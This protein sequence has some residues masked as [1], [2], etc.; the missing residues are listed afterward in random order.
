VVDL[1][2]FDN[3]STRMAAVLVLATTVAMIGDRESLGQTP[4]VRTSD[5]FPL[6]PSPPTT[7]VP[8][9]PATHSGGLTKDTVIWPTRSFAIPFNVTSANHQVVEVQLFV[10]QGPG[11]P[12]RLLDRQPST[13]TEFPFEATSDGLHWFATR[14]AD[15][16]REPQPA[17]PILPQLK[18]LIDST[19]PEVRLIADAD[20]SGRVDVSVDIHDET[21]LRSLQLHYATD[22]VRNWQTVDIQALQ[23]R[24][25]LTFHPAETWQQL[26][27]Q[28]V[29][30]DSAGHQRIVSKLLHRPRI[31]AQDLLPR[32]SQTPSVENLRPSDPKLETENRAVSQ[33]AQYRTD[34]SHPHVHAQQVGVNLG[35]EMDT[36]SKG[37]VDRIAANPY[38]SSFPFGGALPSPATPD[39]VTQGFSGPITK[40]ATPP[41]APERSSAATRSAPATWPSGPATLDSP[42]NRSRSVADAMRPLSSEPSPVHGSGSNHAPYVHYPPQSPSASAPH[43]RGFHAS[44]SSTPQNS[45][46]LDGASGSLATSRSIETIPTPTDAEPDPL[47]VVDRDTSAPYETRRL[48]SPQL[49]AQLW[50]GRV[51]SRYSD[52]R[53][54]S[55]EY[56]LEAVGANGAEAIELWGTTDGAKSWQHWGNDPDLVSPFDIETKEEGVFGFR[57]VVLGRNGLATPRPLAGETPDIAVTVDTTRPVVR[58][59]GAQYGVGDRIGSLVIQYECSDKYLAQRPITLAFSDSPE[60]PWTTIAAGLQ[61]HGE[62][63]WPADPHL[64][65]RLYLRIDA[66]DRAGNVGSY[67]L[68]QPIDTQG[69]APR[70][71]IRGFQT[72]SHSR[73]GGDVPS[74]TPASQAAAPPSA[75]FK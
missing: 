37:P 62:Y 46:D 18:V 51:L 34:A 12:W 57:I 70:A 64:P 75:S 55:L 23:K 43:V 7:T 2:R 60:G 11:T 21:P 22:A 74:S 30:V 20:A 40:P 38:D 42:P 54:F 29:A 39:D 63:V 33:T 68:D 52:S 10:S 50:D 66:T 3:Q 6:A 73:H 1:M 4:M 65:R 58:I 53:R 19:E 69:L 8:A 26:S 48:S 25:T 59:T 67:V 71:R 41:L 32:Y 49:D 45:L 36:H 47:A 35:S 31:A 17:E 27:L 61:N 44:T 9:E 14:T 28:V 56:E 72:L 5:E 13:A 16:G 24:Q 15:H